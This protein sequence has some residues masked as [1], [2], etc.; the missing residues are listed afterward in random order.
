MR[1]GPTLG[2]IARCALLA[3]PLLA[4]GAA[5]AATITLS[6]I[7]T[8]TEA[9]QS[10]DRLNRNGVPS[11][12]PTAKPFPGTIG[13]IT[14]FAVATF[15]AAPGTV[16]SVT[17]NSLT[18]ASFFS[19]YADLFSP[20]TLATNYLGDAGRSTGSTA[21]PVTFSVLA[22]A[23]GV[24]LLVANASFGTASIGE[25]YSATATFTAAEAVVPTPAALPVFAV[26]L[27]GLGLA[28]RRRA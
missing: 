26:A 27:A 5:Q 6:G 15:E 19:I 7:W 22:P 28:L 20:A 8:G 9:L 14:Y 13:D 24:L 10:T 17:D 25:V 16:V 12:A 2:R 21:G 11:V 1:L 18:N 4:G 23:S 3:L